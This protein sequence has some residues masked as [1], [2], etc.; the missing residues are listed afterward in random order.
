MTQEATQFQI[1]TCLTLRILDGW[2]GGGGGGVGEGGMGAKGVKSAVDGTVGSPRS[3]FS[4]LELIKKKMN[5]LLHNYLQ[6]CS[7]EDRLNK[8]A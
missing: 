1:K 5:A 3:S 4:R 6:H 2:G 7:F 8:V